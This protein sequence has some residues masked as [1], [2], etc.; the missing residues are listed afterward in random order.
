MTVAKEDQEKER[1]RGYKTEHWTSDKWTEE[2]RQ[3]VNTFAYYYFEYYSNHVFTN[4]LSQYDA[5]QS[6]VLGGE[7][8]EDSLPGA[9]SPKLLIHSLDGGHLWSG[10]RPGRIGP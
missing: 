2:G 6:G 7:S 5:G 1:K 8:L 9:A 3:E 10:G 4:I